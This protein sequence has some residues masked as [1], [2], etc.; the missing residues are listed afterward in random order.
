MKTRTLVLIALLVGYLVA[1]LPIRVGSTQLTLVGVGD[2]QAPGVP[3]GAIVLMLTSCPASYVEVASLSGR[4]VVGTLA[5]ASDVGTTGGADNVTPAGSNSIPT[6]TGSALATHQHELPFQKIAGGTGVLRML[7]GTI[8]G[9]GTSRAAEAVSA[10][11]TA[12]TTSAAVLL[13]QAISAG[14]PAGTVT[15]PAFTGTSF[16]NRSAFTRVI[17]CQK[18]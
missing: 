11:P 3:S 15:A 1:A 12:N 9:T 16:D 7:P 14:T 17:F 10:A 5:A 8:F 2:A 4:A 18:S 13:A 6:F